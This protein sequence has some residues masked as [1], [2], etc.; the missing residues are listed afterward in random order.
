LR[1]SSG[2]AFCSIALIV[3]VRA[4][5]VEAMADEPSDA[6]LGFEEQPPHPRPEPWWYRR[7]FV[8]H[9]RRPDHSAWA[10]ALIALVGALMALVAVIDLILA[11]DR[12]FVGFDGLYLI[13]LALGLGLMFRKWLAFRLLE[14]WVLWTTIISFIVLL[15]G[16]ADSPGQGSVLTEL[17][18]AIVNLAVL[19]VLLRPRVSRNF[20]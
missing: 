2:P 10:V 3:G 9:P 7:W 11:P 18:N 15:D 14:R 8:R 6:F 5:D 20:D 16:V 12:G 4:A 13:R 19:V 1:T 17:A